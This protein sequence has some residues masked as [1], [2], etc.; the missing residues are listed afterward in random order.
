MDSNQPS[1]KK[2]NK[3]IGTIGENAA[4]VFLGRRGF[5][6]VRRNYWKPWGEIDII[7]EKGDRVHFVEVKAVTRESPGGISHVTSDGFSRV[8]NDYRPE[9][10]VHPAKIKRLKRAIETYIA[11]TGEGRECQIDVVGVFLDVKKRVARCRILEQVL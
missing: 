7:A 1:P 8:I 3:E 5:R 2:R 9:E 4:V 10:Q 6:I 11:E